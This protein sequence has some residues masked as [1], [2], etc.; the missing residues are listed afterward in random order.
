M[1]DV[2][3]RGWGREEWEGDVGKGWCCCRGDDCLG[4]MGGRGELGAFGSGRFR[5]GDFGG[6]V[7]A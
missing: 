5:F 3:G 1:E 4:G 6:I 2:G 7:E